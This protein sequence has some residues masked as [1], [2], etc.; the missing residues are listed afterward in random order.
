[1]HLQH[2]SAFSAYIGAGFI[3]VLLGDGIAGDTIQH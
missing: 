1:M 2:C 3:E